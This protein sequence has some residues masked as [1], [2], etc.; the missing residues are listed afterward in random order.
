MQGEQQAQGQPQ[1]SAEQL[2]PSKM[3]KVQLDAQQLQIDAENDRTKN[4]IA[5]FNAETQRMK[6]VH[7]IQQP[8]RLP[9][10]PGM[11]G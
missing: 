9:R 1:A 3:A 11:T 8:T 2:D 5:S 10:M 7:D 6:A 4:Q